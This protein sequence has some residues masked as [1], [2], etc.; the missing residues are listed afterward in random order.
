MDLAAGHGVDEILHPRP[1]VP[2]IDAVREP[3]QHLTEGLEGFARGFLVALGEV[4][5]AE[6]T[7]QAQV[8]IEVDQA[9]QIKSVIELSACRIEPDETFNTD[10]R[11]D[12]LVIAVLA[13]GGIE[14][15]LLSPDAEWIA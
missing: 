8:F 6:T 14:L 12:A 5:S 10:Q 13:V 3:C 11:L 7:D 9:L 15:G 4:L 2:G 1:C